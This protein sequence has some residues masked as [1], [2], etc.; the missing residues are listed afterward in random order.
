M[1]RFITNQH[2]LLSELLKTYIPASKQLDF[3]VG[4]FYFSGFYRIYKEI[5][6]RKLR[7]LVGME[8]DVTVSHIIREYADMGQDGGIPSNLKIR[9]AFYETAKKIVNQADIV[10]TKEG[11]DAFRFFVGKL[12]NGTL[13]VRK[14]KEP[15]HAKMYIFTNTDE[16]SEGGN[17]PG[18][19]I[20]G[21]SN[22]SFQGLQGRIEVNATL[23]DDSDYLEAEEIFNRLWNDAV[24]LVDQSTKD[25]FFETV[26][27]HTWVDKYPIPYLL[28]VRVLHE[29][30]KDNTETIKTPAALTRDT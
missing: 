16:H 5:S 26:V 30:F 27:E 15:A 13:E 28:Y 29:Y 20:I 9:Q 10:D 24:P 8:A 12:K 4:F 17:Y 1:A 19:V 14:T 11:E 23:R 7:I 21:S 2:D 25:D 18:K 3:L 22:L 6:D